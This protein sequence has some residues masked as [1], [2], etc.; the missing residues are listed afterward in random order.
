M[1][2][3]SSSAIGR[4]GREIGREA[5]RQLRGFPAREARRQLRGF[6]REI[7]RQ[8]GGFGSEIMRQIFGGPKKRQA[9]GRR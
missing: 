9:R 7:P 6:G 1:A 8:L 4:I 5:R 2:N 3:D